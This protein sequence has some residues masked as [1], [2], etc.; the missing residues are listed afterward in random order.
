MPQPLSIRN[1]ICADSGCLKSVD[2]NVV[3]LKL[4]RC[5][6]SVAATLAALPSISEIPFLDSCFPERLPSFYFLI[7]THS[8]PNA[9]SLLPS[10]LYLLCRASRALH[11]YFSIFTSFEAFHFRRPRIGRRLLGSTVGYF[12]LTDSIRSEFNAVVALGNVK[13]L[14]RGAALR[15]SDATTL[16]LPDPASPSSIVSLDWPFDNLGFLS[17]KFR[18]ML[19]Y[20][21]RS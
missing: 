10:S 5:P 18:Q 1:P 17:E 15:P 8:L 3:A 21:V 16:P 9:H 14:G 7:E 6:S 2:K 11:S 19:F 12:R 13:C 4:R 20:V